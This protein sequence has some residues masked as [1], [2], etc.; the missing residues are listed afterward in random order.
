MT[1]VL[2]TGI[3]GSIGCHTHAHILKN[4][5]WHVIGIDSFRHKGLFD[6]VNTIVNPSAI[7]MAMTTMPTSSSR[8]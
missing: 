8:R 6:R 1:K 2:L 3:G 7:T 5:D 4:T